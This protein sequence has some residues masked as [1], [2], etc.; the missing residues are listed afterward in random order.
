MTPPNIYLLRKILRYEFRESQL[1]NLEI[2]RIPED[3][4]DA[5][6]TERF[7]TRVRQHALEGLDL[8]KVWPLPRGASWE[9]G[10]ELQATQRE[11]AA[12]SG[13]K[14]LKGNTVV[15]VL[16]LGGKADKPDKA[17]RKR[18]EELLNEIDDLLVDPGPR[19]LQR[20][21]WRETTL[22]PKASAASL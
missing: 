8:I 1:S 9:D 6:V 15:I 7:A 4:S 5:Y 10:A 12:M 3:V 19:H 11:R 20:A 2:F 13:R 14:T 16:Y 18:I 22:A 21:T 17:E